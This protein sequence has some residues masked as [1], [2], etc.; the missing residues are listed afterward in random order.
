MEWI[1]IS[2]CAFSGASSLVNAAWLAGYV[3]VGG[4]LYG[5]GMLLLGAEEA[6]GVWRKIRARIGGRRS[7]GNGVT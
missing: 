7:A 6:R 4:A 5:G 2:S 1:A 3:A